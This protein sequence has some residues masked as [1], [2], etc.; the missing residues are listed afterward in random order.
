MTEQT[1]SDKVVN[2]KEQNAAFI[3]KVLVRDRAHFYKLVAWLNENV[4]RGRD[5]WTMHK[6]VLMCLKRGDVVSTHI[7]I[8]RP[9]FDINSAVWLNLL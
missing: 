2:N 3:F 5:K 9:D 8:F 4:G 7:Y 1:T 6:R